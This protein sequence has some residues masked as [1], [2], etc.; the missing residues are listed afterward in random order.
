ME[1]NSVQEKFMQE[2]AKIMEKKKQTELVTTGAIKTPLFMFDE[3]GG[4]KRGVNS[5]RKDLNWVPQWARDKHKRTLAIQYSANQNHWLIKE[6]QSEHNGIAKI[7]QLT[8]PD[9][10]IQQLPIEELQKG[11]EQWMGVQSKARRR[12]VP[13]RWRL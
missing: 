8:I 1:P 5:V 6:V 10:D 4:L 3:A 13:K 2:M 11:I 9:H 7:I 12:Q